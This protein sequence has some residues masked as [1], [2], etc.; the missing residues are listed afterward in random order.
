M[1]LNPLRSVLYLLLVRRFRFENACI[2]IAANFL[3]T[4]FLFRYK[5][6]ATAVRRSF[7]RERACSWALDELRSVGWLGRKFPPL[8]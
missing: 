4:C 6:R 2:G 7:V 1:R 8:R 3:S 5:L